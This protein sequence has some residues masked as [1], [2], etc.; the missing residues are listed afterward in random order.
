[1]WLSVW[2]PHTGLTSIEVYDRDPSVLQ[3]KATLNSLLPHRMS[4]YDLCIGEQVV[5][6][7]SL[8]S[9]LGFTD[10]SGY[11]TLVERRSVEVSPVHSGRVVAQH[12]V[13]TCAADPIEQ[14][15]PDILEEDPITSTPRPRANKTMG[16]NTSPRTVKSRSRRLRHTDQAEKYKFPVWRTSR[17]LKEE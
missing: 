12:A 6:D 9:D 17:I 7:C 11:M 10:M 8:L 13:E 16:K 15:P 1:M 3:V 5:D 4:E 14:F 2:I